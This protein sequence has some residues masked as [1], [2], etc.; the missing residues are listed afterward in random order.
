MEKKGK[1][2]VI[3]ASEIMTI[4]SSDIG[5]TSL[6]R[7]F[8]DEEMNI[9]REHLNKQSILT[10]ILLLGFQPCTQFASSKETLISDFSGILDTNYVNTASTLYSGDSISTWLMEKKQSRK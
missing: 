10:L 1:V 2:E 9:Q 7:I 5:S 4:I 6:E 3:V 8:S